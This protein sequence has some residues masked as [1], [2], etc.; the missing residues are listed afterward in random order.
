VQ[1]NVIWERVS[2]GAPAREDQDR[3]LGALLRLQFTL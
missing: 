3:R 1:G 2:G